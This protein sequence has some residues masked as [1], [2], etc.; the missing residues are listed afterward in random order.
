MICHNTQNE[1]ILELP[2]IFWKVIIC[3]QSIVWPL[4]A[5]KSSYI[6]GDNRNIL[7]WTATDLSKNIKIEIFDHW[8]TAIQCYLFLILYLMQF[9][10]THLCWA[11]LYG[12]IELKI[13]GKLYYGKNGIPIFFVALEPGLGFSCQTYRFQ[14]LTFSQKDA[15]E[16]GLQFLCLTRRFPCLTFSQKDALEPGLG[17]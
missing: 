5:I 12:R 9:V 2:P 17:L 3:L 4:T 13:S 10:L 1:F 14:C 15:L 16:T 7:L 11:P 6:F 8:N